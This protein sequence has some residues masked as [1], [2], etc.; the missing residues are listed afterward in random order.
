MAQAV[1]GLSPDKDAILQLGIAEGASAGDAARNF[2]SQSGIETG[3]T[4]SAPVNG[5]AASWAYFGAR[6]QQGDD[7]RGLVVFVE[8][9]G[10]VYQILGY[11]LASRM[12]SYDPVFRRTLSSFA[13]LRDPSALNVQPKRI[14]LVRLSRSMTLEEFAQAYPSTVPTATLGLINGVEESTTL[15]ANRLMKRVVGEGMPE[16]R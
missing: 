12:R 15:Q 5:L 14:E 7:L 4:S 11:T 16:N 13:Q 10:R 3:T 8:H 2:L 1:A 6:T 9:G